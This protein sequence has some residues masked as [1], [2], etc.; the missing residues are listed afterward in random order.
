MSR[1]DI[2][3]ILSVLPDDWTLLEGA[4]LDADGMADLV[5]VSGVEATISHVPEPGNLAI[6]YAVLGAP[7]DPLAVYRKVL[8]GAHL[9][10]KTRS[11][12]IGLRPGSNELAAFAA[13]PLGE[14]F[15]QRFD[16]VSRAFAEDCLIW[17][18]IVAG[19]DEAEDAEEHALL[20]PSARI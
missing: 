20:D 7:E 6:L 12:T 3:D 14:G 17:A 10:D 11:V 9:W 19:L 4:G 16:D 18:G 15:G 1:Q 5:H 8:E 2:E 13:I